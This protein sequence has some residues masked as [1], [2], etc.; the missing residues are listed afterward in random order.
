M[1]MSCWLGKAYGLVYLNLCG[2]IVPNKQMEQCS[3]LR[4]ELGNKALPDF[5]AIQ[6]KL[7][8]R[9]KGWQVITL[10]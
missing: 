7:M 2:E 9:I 5:V 10:L 4:S 1:S 6:F 3:N 8:L